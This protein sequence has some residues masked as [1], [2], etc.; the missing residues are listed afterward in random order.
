MYKNTRTHTYLLLR[1]L[2]PVWEF[3]WDFH[4][5]AMVN[6]RYWRSRTVKMQILFYIEALECW[7]ANA[8]ILLHMLPNVNFSCFNLLFKNVCINKISEKN[9]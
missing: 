8:R 1:A 2:W 9:S 7:W 3:A 4:C 6:N 5:V